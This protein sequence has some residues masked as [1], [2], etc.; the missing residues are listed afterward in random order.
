MKYFL[1]FQQSGCTFR[2]RIGEPNAFDAG[3]GRIVLCFSDLEEILSNTLLQLLVLIPRY[4]R[5]ITSELS[6][7]NKVDMMASLVRQR[8]P[9]T[10]FNVG[11]DPPVETLDEL[12][13]IL[14]Q[15]EELHNKIM[16]ASWVRMGNDER[17]EWVKL[18][19]KASHGLREQ[20]EE[21]GPDELLDIADYIG[22][23]R[24]TVE[25]FFLAVEIRSPSEASSGDESTELAP[26]TAVQLR[27]KLGEPI[28]A[29]CPFKTAKDTTH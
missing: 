10:R 1:E 3:I 25:E 5:I 28:R 6:F 8:L 19:A 11:D 12:V 23:V 21:M 26:S 17:W 29:C 27:S 14:F 22:Y 18:T 13:K 7:K 24:M 15:A 20:S 2:E 4:G 9:S 16:H